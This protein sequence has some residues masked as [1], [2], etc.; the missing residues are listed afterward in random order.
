MR[1]AVF[2]LVEPGPQVTVKVNPF[3]NSNILIYKAQKDHV[4]QIKKDYSRWLQMI[5]VF[6]MFIISQHS[7]CVATAFIT[8][9]ALK[10]KGSCGHIL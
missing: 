8:S 7:I 2:V 4:T 3:E 1:F 10:S 9:V 5:M 6:I